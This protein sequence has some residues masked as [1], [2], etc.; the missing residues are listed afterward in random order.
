MAHTYI[1]G[2]NA[3]L[4][5]GLLLMLAVQCYCQGY[6]D[7]SSRIELKPIDNVNSIIELAFSCG[8]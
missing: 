6:V 7:A 3:V 2:Y 5:S 4:L 1:H 8:E